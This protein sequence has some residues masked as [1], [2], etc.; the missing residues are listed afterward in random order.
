MSKNYPEIR[1]DLIK[2]IGKVR[3]GLPELMNA[4]GS[5]SKEAYSDGALDAKTKELMALAIG[6]AIR[7]DGCIAFHS[8]GALLKGAT[9]EEVAETI[10]VAIQ[11]GG[12][13]SVVYGSEALMAYDQFAE[14]QA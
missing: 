8:R 12:G 11:M 9:R 14:Q 7:C 3:K 1:T 5:L 6:V 4:S 2:S 10:G 13:P